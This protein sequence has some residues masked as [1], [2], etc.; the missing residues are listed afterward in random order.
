MA[1]YLV[2]VDAP[3]TKPIAQDDVNPRMPPGSPPALYEHMDKALTLP[4]RAD[5]VERH[6]GMALRAYRQR[7][8]EILEKH[9]N[10]M[11]KYQIV[12][13]HE[14]ASLRAEN[15]KLRELIGAK[16][17]D[18]NF[19]QSVLFQTMA[20]VDSGKSKK[21]FKKQNLKVGRNASDDDEDNPQLKLK[22]KKTK[23]WDG[24]AAEPPG[25]SWQQFMA[26]VP[27]GS[28]LMNPEPWRP[29]EQA[30]IQ[31]KARPDMKSQKSLPASQGANA[32]VS[33]GILPGSVTENKD[34]DRNQREEDDDGS[35]GCK[36]EAAPVEF[37]LIDVW[38]PSEKEKKMRRT[39]GNSGELE[40]QFSYDHEDSLFP[41]K[42]NRFILNPDSNVRIAWDMGSLFMVVYDMIM[43][44]MQFFEMPETTFLLAMDWTTRVFWTLDMGWS[45]CTGVVLADGAV[46]Y[47]V[48]SIIKRYLKSWFALDIFIVGSDWAG[49][50]LS[51]GGLGVSRIARVSRVARVVRLLRLVRMQ[52]VIANIT[53][54]IQGDN[55]ILMLQILKVL[56]F[57]MAC[58][59]ATACGW[60]G[61]GASS[62]WVKTY[63]YGSSDISLQYLASLH[64]S[65]SQ[66]SGGLEEF[67]PTT[68]TERVYTVL[69]WLVSFISGMVM[70]SFLTSRLTQQY[71]IGGSGARQMATL[72][73]YLK[74]NRI[75]KYLIKRLCRSATQA[76]SGDL[77][78]ESVD[79]LHVVSEPLRIEMHYEMYSRILGFHPFFVDFMN[80]GN[81][82][83]RRVCHSCMS[84][85]LLDAGDVLFNDGDEPADPKM[86][87][88]CSGVLKYVD[89]YGE[90]TDVVEKMYVSEAAL[91][92]LWRHQGTLTAHC[93]SKLAV[94][95]AEQFQDVCETYMRKSR[96]VGFN[97]KAYAAAYVNELNE[98]TE[99]SDLPNSTK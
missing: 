57:L 78:P 21:D 67:G 83:I 3:D 80:Q 95:E 6:L 28:A 99:W 66:F 79:L 10:D 89:K 76:I 77:Q 59:H 1:G 98:T 22:S 69:V 84:M 34:R 93:D 9:F 25:G 94:L 75:P 56:V 65:L 43:I 49:V 17:D 8:E 15:A 97:P 88:V 61:V 85:L 12:Q 63:G 35:D 18:P 32:V 74:Q 92:T 26:W 13:D 33:F 48:R 71:I 51:S 29:L 47:D 41:H 45:C 11:E 4:E 68:G 37:E 7:S 40:S 54:R 5:E 2:Q 52:E 14:I 81:Q 36:S 30:A 20:P 44:P 73:K 86:Y 96:G 16:S 62:G 38:K 72:K 60:F 70:L 19:L 24:S 87:F 64:W 39:Q 31:D 50:V 23:A 27:N 46:E 53:E 90:P 58:C 55:T 82:A 42:A 91:W